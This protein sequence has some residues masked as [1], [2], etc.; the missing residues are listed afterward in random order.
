M[1][2]TDDNEVTSSCSSRGSFPLP[3]RY[4]VE[5]ILDVRT[6]LT[7][8]V[9]TCFTHSAVVL[10]TL[11][12]PGIKP[13]RNNVVCSACKI[14]LGPFRLL[15]SQKMH[16]FMSGNGKRQHVFGHAPQ[17]LCMPATQAEKEVIEMSLSGLSRMDRAMRRRRGLH[18]GEETSRLAKRF[19]AL[20]ALKMKK[21]AQ[22]Q[23]RPGML[24]LESDR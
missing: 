12:S 6:P 18:F 16:I 19:P 14:C 20:Q 7:H 3:C 10:L 2:A 21:L 17:C 1:V 22:E 9:Q 15:W 8:A 13:N 11:C 24:P 4:L 5:E 23:S